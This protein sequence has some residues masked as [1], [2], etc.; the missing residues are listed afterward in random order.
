M[1][2]ALTEVVHT[3][4]DQLASLVGVA[5]DLPTLAQDIAGRYVS[6]F[7]TGMEQT[8]RAALE[9]AAT[10]YRATPNMTHG[11]LI[12][13]L[14]GG[15]GARRAELI[16]ITAA[17]EAASKAVDS[18]QAQ[19]KAAGIE[20]EEVWQTVADE[21]TCP[22]CGPLHGKPQS[23]WGGRDIPAHFRCRCFKTLRSVKKK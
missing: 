11:E 23:A 13:L 6:T 15:F 4:V 19:L 14:R 10:L 22:I 20:M 2:G 12:Q 16:A 1:V 17:T 5:F 18:Y 9:R 21:R 7:F 3:Q 8:T